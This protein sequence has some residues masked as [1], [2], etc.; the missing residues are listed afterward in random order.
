MQPQG[1]Y[2]HRDDCPTE[3]HIVRLAGVSWEDYERL[4]A[5][6]G[7]HSAPRIAYLE[8]EVDI[9]SPSRTH[10]GIKL[11]A[12]RGYRQALGARED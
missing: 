9:M 3:D 1:R 12:I 7:D 11:D 4:L 6:R 8:G 2:E 10:E 5:T